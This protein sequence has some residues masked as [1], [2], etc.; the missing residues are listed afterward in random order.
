[1]HEHSHS[2]P[3]YRF[4]E[5]KLRRSL[6]G[7]HNLRR[8]K[9]FRDHEYA[10]LN[11][12]ESQTEVMPVS[13]NFSRRFTSRV[14]GPSDLWVFWN[15]KNHDG[16]SRVLNLSVGGLCLSI[17]KSERIAVGEK[18]HLNFLTPEG[19]IRTD[20]IVRHIQPQRLGLK[21]I[22]I[23]EEDRAHLTALM[24]RLR[25]TSRSQT[26]FGFGPW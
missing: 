18:V 3:R 26:R 4:S 9:V 12:Q 25:D 13:Q 11:G 14:A 20:A 8:S 17:D 21:F 10:H 24:T 7:H 22:A 19:Q 2:A 5:P 23:R 15:R 16:L 1:M 6:I